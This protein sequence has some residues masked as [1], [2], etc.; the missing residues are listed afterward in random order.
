MQGT[1]EAAETSAAQSV[2]DV[3]AYPKRLAVFTLETHTTNRAIKQFLHHAVYYSEPMAS[4][5][6]RSADE[7]PNCSSSGSR[8]PTSFRRTTSSRSP[9]PP[10]IGWFAI[11]SPG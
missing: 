9:T 7:S 5:R 8:I 4:E 2:D 3:R 6:R 11:T 1:I 10:Y